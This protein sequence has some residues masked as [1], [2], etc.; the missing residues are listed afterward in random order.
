M[1]VVIVSQPAA[2]NALSDKITWQLRLDDIGSYPEEKKLAFKLNV[3]GNDVTVLKSVRP[4]STS[5]IIE[6]DFTKQIATY[7]RSR[8]RANWLTYKNDAFLAEVYLSYGDITY[9]VEECEDSVVSSLSQTS[10]IKVYNSYINLGEDGISSGM[11]FTQR[12]NVYCITEET[13]DLWWALDAPASVVYYKNGQT[14]GNYNPTI[15]E[16]DVYNFNRATTPG[17][18]L[19]YDSYEVTINGKTYR[20]GF[21]NCKGKYNVYFLEPSGGWSPMVFKDKTGSMTVDKQEAFIENRADEYIN[22]QE[23]TSYGG[24][25]KN[26]VTYETRVFATAEQE[27]YLKAFCGASYY[28]VY[29]NGQY[30]GFVVTQKPTYYQN[31]KYFVLNITGYLSS[32][33]LSH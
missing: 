2:I 10:M 21:K 28:M 1:G 5:D 8:F 24:V 14:V 29:E 16:G 19:N 32:P 17:F 25:N 23:F 22:Y 15:A 9:N 12:P 13:Q 30:V 18:T 33:Y 20:A 3:N 26:V 11:A 31:A 4:T 7:L 27:Q 6:V